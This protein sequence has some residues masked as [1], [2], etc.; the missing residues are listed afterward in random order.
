[1]EGRPV[2]T[3]ESSVRRFSHAYDVG[4]QFDER[5]AAEAAGYYQ[6]SLW[7]GSKMIAE[8]WQPRTLNFSEWR[9][10]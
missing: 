9:T 6:P 7:D 1:M 2:G 8:K 4:F 10:I 5:P 3:V